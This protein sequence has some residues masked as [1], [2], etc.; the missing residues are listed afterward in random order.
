M[1]QNIKYLTRDQRLD[2]LQLVLNSIKLL[3]NLFKQLES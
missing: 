3:Q 2:P 1:E